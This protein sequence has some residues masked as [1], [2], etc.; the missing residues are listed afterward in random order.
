MEE[1]GGRVLEKERHG[2]RDARAPCRMRHV[3]GLGRGQDALG[4]R[5]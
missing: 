3:P 2:S 5:S 4:L 1:S